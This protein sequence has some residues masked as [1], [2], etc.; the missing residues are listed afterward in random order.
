MIHAAFALGLF[1]QV[2]A[3]D[4]ERKAV[5]KAIEYLVKSQD[6]D[7]S[8]A[9]NADAPGAK[10]I[11]RFG[12]P[13]ER[14]FATSL[15]AL[16]LLE[17]GG[18]AESVTRAARY[19]TQYVTEGHKTAVTNPTWLFSV[20]G[21]LLARLQKLAPTDAN[22]RACRGILQGL[23]EFVE[24]TDAWGHGRVDRPNIKVSIGYNDLAAAHNWVCLCLAEMKRAGID[25]PERMMSRALGFYD[26]AQFP[27]GGLAYNLEGRRRDRS[28]ETTLGEGRS[29]AQL[30]GLLRLAPGS[31]AAKRATSYAR[32]HLESVPTHH[33]PWLHMVAGRWGLEDLG[34]GD[35][36]KFDKLWRVKIVERLAADGHARPWNEGK[37]TSD[38]MEQFRLSA[39]KDGQI[40]AAYSTACFLLLL[41]P[42]GTRPAPLP[43]T[44]TESNSGKKR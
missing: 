32:L 15:A 35:V 34:A 40:G 14:V 16:A 12:K 13:P 7:G 18:H 11:A 31:E 22:A 23:E 5:A 21:L 30:P 29:V 19:V 24:T 39:D 36:A 43:D 41:K 8:W 20:G 2:P 33:T 3:V 42:A 17:H 6:A 26:K 37:A 44:P 28:E 4:A 10:E 27:G 9:C 1:L 38:F 25:V